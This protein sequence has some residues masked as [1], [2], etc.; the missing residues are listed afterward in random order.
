MA[1]KSI[2][3]S[4]TTVTEDTPTISVKQKEHAKTDMIECC[5]IT[6]GGLYVTGNRTGTEY[7]WADYG[8]VESVEYQD[9]LYMIRGNKDAVYKPRFIILDDD[10]VGEH[11]SL[12]KLY[13]SLYNTRDLIQILG[14]PVSEMKKV[15][16]GLPSG[17]VDALKNLAATKI[18]NGE[19]D[20]ISKIR[21]LD[22]IFGTEFKEFVRK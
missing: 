8:D 21:A 9:L 13:D 15:V 11:P 2:I 4:S 16:K 14:L 19:I 1:R 10:I 22:E 5:S 12:K 17:A 3:N 7:Q 18:E 20:S 6:S